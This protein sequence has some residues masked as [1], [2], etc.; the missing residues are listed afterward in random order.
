MPVRLDQFRVNREIGAHMHL[1]RV[2]EHIRCYEC[3]DVRDKV[4]ASLGMAMDVTEIDITPYYSKPVEVLFMNVARFLLQKSDG[5]AL[6]FLGYVVRMDGTSFEHIYDEPHRGSL[7]SWLPDWRE[8]IAFCT[9]D[10]CISDDDFIKE[11][12]Y[13]ASRHTALNADIVD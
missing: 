9:F 12:T 3:E 7:P 8:R 1:I 13:S 11:P 5:H 6:D 10:N 2:L 4:S